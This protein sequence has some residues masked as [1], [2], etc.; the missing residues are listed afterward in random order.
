MALPSQSN[1]QNQLQKQSEAMAKRKPT[2]FGG[3]AKQKTMQAHQDHS[4][5]W[6][7]TELDYNI[8]HFNELFIE[9]LSQSLSSMIVAKKPQP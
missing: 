3:A 6:L 8:K 5:Q 1:L 4:N 9:N 2:T 7:S